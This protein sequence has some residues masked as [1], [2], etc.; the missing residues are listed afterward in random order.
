M[1]PTDPDDLNNFFT[2][3]ERG[4]IVK[5][6]LDRTVFTPKDAETMRLGR[7]GW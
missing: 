2:N 3:S 7:L 6:I 4:L 5:E 1:D